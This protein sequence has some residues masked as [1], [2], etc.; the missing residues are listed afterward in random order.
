MDISTDSFPPSGEDSQWIVEGSD[1]TFMQDVIEASKH[2]L[3]LVDFWA[4]WCGPCK[5]LIPNLEKVVNQAAGEVK[6]V[7]IN[8]DENQGVAGQLGVRSVPTVF[9]FK[10]GQPVDGF[11]GAIPETQIV[12]FIK[13]AGAGGALEQ[14]EQALAAA[15]QAFQEGELDQS[16]GIYAQILQAMPDNSDAMIG[17]TRCFVAKGEY[18]KAKDAINAMSPEMQ[19]LPQVKSILTA[20]ELSDDGSSS[21]SSDLETRIAENPDD[22]D[23]KFDFAKS[24][25]ANGDH[26]KAA[27][28]LLEILEK[29]LDWNEGAAKDQLLKI[30]EA[31]GPTAEVSKTGR[32]RLSSLL[33]S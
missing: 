14:I 24:L 17:L 7:K 30:F 6:L 25:S 33:F 10:D 1:Q 13:K 29:D 27:D 5:T 12:D 11:Q 22:F 19:K 4:P 15:S 20:I 18:N 2:S 23:A 8:I 26:E 21:N 31:A 16:A 3:V 9:A 28:H 32:R